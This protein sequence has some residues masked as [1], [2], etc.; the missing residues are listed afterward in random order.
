M[1][2]SLQ[3]QT[4]AAAN[5]AN[6]RTTDRCS[7]YA[8]NQNVQHSTGI[9]VSGVLSMFACAAGSNYATGS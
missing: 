2:C 3:L 7:Q 6:H 1:V 8:A 4:A 9:Q 5:A